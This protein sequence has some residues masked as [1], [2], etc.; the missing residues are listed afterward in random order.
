MDQR[1]EY[2]AGACAGVSGEGFRVLEA[3]RHGNKLRTGHL[4]G[5]R[6]ELLLRGIAEDGLARAQ[7]IAA[8][9]AVRGLLNFYGPQ[10]FGRFGDNAEVGALLLRGADDP[11]VR[12]VRDRVQRRFL[13]SAFQ[14]EI[15]NRVLAERIRDGSWA[16]PQ[17]GDVLQKLP[18]GGLF[19]CEDP[20]VD[21]PR[22]A[23]F[24]L[25]ITGPM[26][27]ARMRP[28]P[29]G[30]PAALEERLLA[31][32][33]V[34]L[35][36]LAASRDAE[37]ARRPLRLPVEIALREDPEGLRISFDLPPGSYATVVLREIVK[38][39]LPALEA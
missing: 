22:V 30:E 18:A 20:D 1:P 5:N 33:G 31:E 38:G 4:R 2:R 34:S 26:P 17:V 25:S 6:F 7:A 29:G 15:F 39:E 28:A 10:R 8:A 11:R 14:S 21:A 9:L 16:L 32:T 13:I 27:G 37:G 23:S 3:A 36:Q 24:E 19:V 12:R 35:E